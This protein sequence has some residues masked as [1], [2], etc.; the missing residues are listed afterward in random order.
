MPRYKENLH[1]WHS[2]NSWLHSINISDTHIKKYFFY[3]A[4]VDYFPGAKNGSHRVPTK[5]EIAKESPRLKQLLLDFNPEIV[6]PVG[7]LSIS[8]CLRMTFKNLSDVLGKAY[9]VDPYQFLKTEKIVI[10]LPHPSG[11]STW[12]Y[13]KGNKILL[14]NV[15]KLLK[16]ELLK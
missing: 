4:L 9:S 5:E 2:L 6:V 13:K 7:K 1:D 15:L 11:A 12:R 8:L 3:S 10:P 14:Q 16:S